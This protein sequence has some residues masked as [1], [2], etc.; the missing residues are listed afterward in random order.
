MEDA[1]GNLFALDRIV[2]I[3]RIVADIQ[4]AAKTKAWKKA[5]KHQYGGALSLGADIHIVKRNLESPSG[6]VALD[7][8]RISKRTSTVFGVALATP[9]LP[10]LRWSEPRG[11]EGR[12]RGMRRTIQ[13]CG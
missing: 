4:K 13:R 1:E 11:C 10:I 6:V 12:R 5:A 7:A 3:G 2:P 9:R 8:E